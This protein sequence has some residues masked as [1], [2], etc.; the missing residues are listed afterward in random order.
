LFLGAR[1]GKA[2][3]VLIAGIEVHRQTNTKVKVKVKNAIIVHPPRLTVIT[4]QVG[5]TAIENLHQGRSHAKRLIRKRPMI[6]HH[7]IQSINIEKG[8][9]LNH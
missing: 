2:V 4:D 1:R 3:A 9:T 8:N 7:Q 6:I 5:G